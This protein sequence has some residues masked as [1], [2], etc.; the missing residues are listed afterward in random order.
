VVGVGKV[1]E[2]VASVVDGSLDGVGAGR[3]KGAGLRLVRSIT[4]SLFLRKS[5]LLMEWDILREDLIVPKIFFFKVLEVP[6][7]VQ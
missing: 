2:R 6:N 7:L 5:F 3:R 4:N 1:V